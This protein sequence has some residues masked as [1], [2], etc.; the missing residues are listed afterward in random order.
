[1]RHELLVLLLLG[2]CAGS[3]GGRQA[4]PAGAAGAAGAASRGEI[5]VLTLSPEAA[6]RRLVPDARQVAFRASTVEEKALYADLAAALWAGDEDQAAGLA[7]RAAA[8]GVAIERWN[9]AGRSYLVVRERERARH[10]AGTYAVRLPGAGAGGAAGGAI[11]LEAPHSY[12]DVG[13]GTIAASLFFSPDAPVALHGLFV[14][15]L[16]RYQ[17]RPGARSRRPDSPA[18]VCHNPEHVFQ[19]ATW[20]VLS[21][22]GPLV[23]AQ[24]H[25]FESAGAA[26]RATGAGPEV[27][28]SAGG[29][30]STPASTAVATELGS[31]L[32]VRVA[33]FPEDTRQLGATT[34][35]QGRMAR[36]A[37]IA[38]VH[39]EMA[40]A[41]RHRLR[42][43]AGAR[44]MLGRALVAALAASQEAPAP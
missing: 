36:S 17:L 42:D 29:E 21:A 30:Q 24:L 33:R 19:A 8:L 6:A 7:G 20:A 44:A 23:L 35:V 5:V 27:I 14:N 11:L 12:F 9:V 38:F 43:D 39:V 15:S 4:A 10:G 13:T 25:G 1:M 32:G 18:D 2:G 28:V 41:V 16:H 34:N 40:P 22:G 26:A 37:G 31:G 3:C